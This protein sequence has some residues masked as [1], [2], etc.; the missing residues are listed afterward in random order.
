MCQAR[1]D[2]VGRS[3]YVYILS[4]AAGILKIGHTTRHPEDRADEWRLNLLAYARAEDSADA[5]KRMHNYLSHYRKGSYELFELSFSE[6]ISALEKVVGR[7]TILR[8]PP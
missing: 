7:A 2:P 5:E 1:E 8:S 4:L 6:A 3:G